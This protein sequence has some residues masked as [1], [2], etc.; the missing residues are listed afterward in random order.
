MSSEPHHWNGLSYT[1]RRSTRSRSLRLKV[2]S[3]GKVVVSSPPRVS[4]N[5]VERFLESHQSW[6]DAALSQ[7]KQ[8]QSPVT[9]TKI[10]LFGVWHS[11]EVTHQKT[12]PLGVWIQGSVVLV[13]PVRDH[14]SSVDKAIT[15]FLKN[16]A[17]AYIV[18]RV[19]ELAKIMQQQPLSISLRQQKTRW[20]SCSSRGAL[21]FNWRLVHYAPEVIDYV[22]IHELAHLE[23]MNHSTRFWALVAKYDPNYQTH[24][25]W[26][27]QHGATTD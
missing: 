25:N 13:H 18:P 24:R 10:M 5:Q 2:E 7:T 11:I 15:R 20:G 26:L 12:V 4:I 17:Q 9:N 21:N 16:T 1:W 3:G 6:L 14:Q 8:Q 19:H 23:H 22:I 27:R